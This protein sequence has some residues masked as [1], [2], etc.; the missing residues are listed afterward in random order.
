[1]R[2]V[3]KLWTRFFWIETVDALYCS[4][5]RGILSSIGPWLYSHWSSQLLKRNW[6]YTECNC[7]RFV[8]L[9]NL[10]HTEC[11]CVSSYN[12][13]H[14]KLFVTW[15]RV[16]DSQDLKQ[17]GAEVAGQEVWWQRL[18]CIALN[19]RDRWFMIP[20]RSCR[21]TQKKNCT[22]IFSHC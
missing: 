11:T 22:R 13:V 15:D 14:I 6:V 21:D 19:H 1:M 10:I 3:S 4:L 9:H 7:W 16:R 2:L 18:I 5:F 8:T 20:W 12:A 17:Y